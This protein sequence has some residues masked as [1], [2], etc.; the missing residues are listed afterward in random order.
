M[1]D[2]TFEYPYVFL[3]L[4]IFLLCAFFCKAKSEAIIFPHL[5]IFMQSSANKT[6]FIK[7]L[8]WVAIVSAV[9]A[10]ASP[11]TQ[12]KL[13]VS[14]QEG[15]AIALVLDASGSME[16]GF[17]RM[18]GSVGQSKF[19]I[20]MEMAQEFVEKRENDQ[21]GLVVFG[22]FAYVAA[23]LT[24]DK[25]IIWQI[26][27]GLSAGIAGRTQTVIN[28]ALFQSSKLFKNS[29]A[30]TKIAILLTDGQSR[31]D[32]VP[33][34]VAMRLT[35]QYEVKVYTIGIG[36]QGEFNKEHLQIIAN[37]SGGQFF[38]ANDKDA[39]KEIYNK[40]DQLEKSKIESEKYIKKS[41]YFEYPLFLAFVA[42]LLFIYL[43]NIRGLV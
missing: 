38:S 18:F 33:F 35:Q 6:I 42:L 9:V 5:D 37:K 11:I 32:N 34:D 22:D 40:I 3:L 4:A 13:E 25:K 43:R 28:D 12:D 15:Y 14:N 24:Y 39:L 30:K 29:K 36:N 17:Q 19:D 16:K 10:L 23:P 27:G 8:K 20:S 2:I 1:S 31:G 26:M 41:Y 21:L 7:I